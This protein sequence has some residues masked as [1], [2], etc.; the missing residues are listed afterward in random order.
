ME[1]L[2]KEELSESSSDLTGHGQEGGP[3]LLSSRLIEDTP[4]DEDLFTFDDDIGPHDRVAQVVADLVRSGESGGKMIGLEGGWGAGKTTVVKLLQKQ[5]ARDNDTTLFSFDAWAHE[6]DP[7]RRTYLESITKHFNN[8]KNNGWIDEK[9]WDKKLEELTKRHS[10]RV[11]TT[12]PKIT[13]FGKLLAFSALLVPIGVPIVASQLS[14]GIVIDDGITIFQGITNI[15]WFIPGIVCAGAPLIT[16]ILYSFFHLFKSKENDSNDSKSAWA[17]LTGNTQVDI[18]QK[19]TETP[20]PTSIEFENYF[21]EL[22]KEA[23]EEH[24]KRK[25]VLV[26]DNLDRIDLKSALSNWSTLQTFLQD[27]DI[28]TEEWF[29]RLWVIIPYDPSGL[30][31]LWSNHGLE[32]G[33]ERELPVSF[34][35][36]SFLVRFVVPPMVL[37]NWKMYLQ[38]L[39]EYA[40]PE[41]LAEDY[42]T[43]CSVFNL[44]RVDNNDAP[45]PRE[46]K[47]YMNQIVATYRQWQDDYPR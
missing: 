1:H 40:L 16:T 13:T 27:R 4:A 24:K 20:D 30:R 21:S 36:K 18:T 32:N 41:H 17:I 45:T 23:L 35:D 37:S 46:L 2:Q 33:L 22:M 39:A 9:K 10:T 26:I 14:P 8:I 34:M 7:L 28:N 44:N 42:H 12:N 3:K 25:V 29:K 5:L 19:T 15:W 11:T 43:I 31:R 47:L 6:G 38:K